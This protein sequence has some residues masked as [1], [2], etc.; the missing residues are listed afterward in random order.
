VGDSRNISRQLR[1]SG[2]NSW[3]NVMLI[4]SQKPNA[5]HVSDFYAWHKLAAS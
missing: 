3:H 2:A 4:A 1:A 5:T